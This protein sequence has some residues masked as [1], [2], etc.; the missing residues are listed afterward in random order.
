MIEQ[1]TRMLPCGLMVRTDG[2]QVAGSPLRQ[3]GAIWSSA[4]EAAE[5]ATVPAGGGVRRDR[6]DKG[7]A[8]N[9]KT[10]THYCSRKKVLKNLSPRLAE[11]KLSTCRGFAMMKDNVLSF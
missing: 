9:V 3:P 7:S 2:P 11:P 1:P 4:R 8:V 5:K 6:S 10:L